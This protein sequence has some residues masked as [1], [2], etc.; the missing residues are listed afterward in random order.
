MRKIAG[1]SVLFALVG[2]F[3]FAACG[4]NGDDGEDHDAFDTYQMCWDEHHTME[5][6]SIQRAIDVPQQRG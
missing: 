1:F 4:D 3:T 2:S 6:F 5:G